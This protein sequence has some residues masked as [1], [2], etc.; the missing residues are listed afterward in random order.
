VPRADQISLDPVVL[1]FAAGA[2][3]L[4]AFVCALA[5]A[6]F[7][8]SR[9][10]LSSVRGAAHSTTGDRAVVASRRAVL[11]LQVAVVVVLLVGSGLL[12]RSF[13]RLQHVDLG[14]SADGVVTM[15]MRLLNPKYREPG[16]LA[17]FNR[18]LLQRM[19][20]VP[21]VANASVTTAVP[22]RGVDFMM[23][24][25]PEGQ[26]ALPGNARWVDPEYF[27]IMHLRLLAG[28]IFTDG[29]TATSEPVTVVSESYGRR[30]FGAAS[31]LGRTLK[32]SDGRFRI[33]GVVRDTRY[34][35]AAREPFPAF[36]LSVSQDPSELL[37]LV[38]EPQPGMRAAVVDG[39]RTAIQA[40]DA[41]QPV[42]G[43]TTIDQIVSQ[44][45][46]DRRFYAVATGAF[47]FVA[48]ALAIAGVF[49]VVSRTVGERKREL[50][51]RAALGA[52]PRRLVTAV[53]GY[54][55]VPAAI[56]TAIGLAVAFAASRLLQSFLFEIAP[57]DAATYAGATALVIA[58]TAAA[59]YLPARRALRVPPMLV[60][61]TD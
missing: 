43:I 44:S 61:K 45:T 60:L 10:L 58:V 17:A 48:L 20:A 47:A 19:R 5:P 18:E 15:E 50:A 4:T 32:T 34:A 13:W 12:L 35:N 24:I 52:E 31:P 22:M 55:V 7:V 54:G 51:I 41:E 16:R 30:Y 36:Y 53:Y 59:C 27:K 29:D 49:G 25:G 39:M 57:T 56:G 42:E 40:L 23:V 38:A 46:A 37:C 2:M 3:L 28:R 14:F 1:A 11:V 6:W 26:T 21:G 8:L 9:D 33:I